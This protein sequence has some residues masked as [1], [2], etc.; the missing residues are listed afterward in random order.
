[1]GEIAV[2]ARDRERLVSV[3]AVERRLELE[4]RADLVVA[5]EPYRGVADLLG[6][7]VNLFAGLLGKGIAEDSTEQADV[8]AQRGVLLGSVRGAKRE[9]LWIRAVRSIGRIR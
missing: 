5:M 6:R 1:M 7:F 4:P 2:G 9:R 3:E 8:V